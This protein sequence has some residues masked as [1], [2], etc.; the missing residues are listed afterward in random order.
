[1]VRSGI[2]PPREPPMSSSDFLELGT[3]AQQA[4]YR[5]TT[6]ARTGRQGGPF[7]ANGDVAKYQFWP[8]LLMMGSLTGNVFTQVSVRCHHRGRNE[9][10]ARP[11]AQIFGSHCEKRDDPETGHGRSFVA[12]DFRRELLVVK[13]HFLLDSARLPL[14]LRPLDAEISFDDIAAQGI[15]ITNTLSTRKDPQSGQNHVFHNVQMSVTCRR[16][17]KYYTEFKIDEE[18]KQ[19]I[20][21]GK[22]E[23]EPYRRRATA[24]DFVISPLVSWSTD[25]ADSRRNEMLVQSA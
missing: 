18:T 23:F 24:M 9:A 11:N 6:K 5:A 25:D 3:K 22:R 17:P 13:A 4:K 12:F 19:S 15:Q 7:A 21:M 8:D 16:P 10:N 20:G 1:M 14:V 2:A